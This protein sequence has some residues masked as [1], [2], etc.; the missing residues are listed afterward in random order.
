MLAAGQDG[1]PAA[2]VVGRDGIVEWIGHPMGIDEPLDAI[3]AGSWDREAAKEELERQKEMQ[4]QFMVALKDIG[5][6]IKNEQPQD[7]VA[8]IHSFLEKYPDDVRIALFG[9]SRLTQAS[10]VETAAAL[11]DG[12]AHKHWDDAEPLNAIAWTLANLGE[13][14]LLE[15]ALKITERSK[16]LTAEKDA[17]VLDTLARIH[18]EQGN[19]EAAVEWQQKCVDIGE[20]IPSFQERLEE[21][22]KKLEETG[23]LESDGDS[24]NPDASDSSE[25][26]DPSNSSNKPDESNDRSSL[27]VEP[28]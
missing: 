10:H 5:E 27:E 16:E 13:K 23:Q 1:I 20:D 18:F 11:A 21:Y 2:F 28:E 25:S 12:V 15:T 8:Q 9:I 24:D 26:S 17:S 6:A 22:R 4:K 14:S 7:A 19:L 3:V